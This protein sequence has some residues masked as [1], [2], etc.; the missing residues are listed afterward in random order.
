MIEGAM[1]CEKEIGVQCGERRNRARAIR[2]LAEMVTMPHLSPIL[3]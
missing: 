3:H 1:S 2:S